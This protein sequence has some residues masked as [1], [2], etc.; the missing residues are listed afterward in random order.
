MDE[1]KRNA[2][3]E[4]LQPKRKEVGLPNREKTDGRIHKTRFSGIPEKTPL[5][6]GRP[7][8]SGRSS[9][10]SLLIS[11]VSWTVKTDIVTVENPIWNELYFPFA[12]DKGSKRRRTDTSSKAAKPTKANANHGYINVILRVVFMFSR[13]S[14]P[15]L[16]TQRKI[17]L[18]KHQ[19]ILIV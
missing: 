12:Q 16:P 19:S 15:P 6:R 5:V 14:P 10:I 1:K 9:S 4:N 2:R 8:F 13:T 11:L 3:N 18:V 7:L 17:I